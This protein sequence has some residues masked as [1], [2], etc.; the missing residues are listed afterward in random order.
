[1]Q[2]SA[3]RW[4]NFLPAEISCPGIGK[5]LIHELALDKVNAI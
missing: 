4:P 2:E 1:V 3:W 5:L